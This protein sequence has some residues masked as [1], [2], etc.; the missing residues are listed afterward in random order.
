VPGFR[1]QARRLVG[2]ALDGD[3]VLAAGNRRNERVVAERA[4]RQR[5]AL[6]VV[7]AHVLFREHQHMM[8]EPGRANGV[9]FAGRK[10]RGQV[11]AADARAT[12]LSTRLDRN[13]HRSPSLAAVRFPVI[14]S[15]QSRAWASSP[16]SEK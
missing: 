6:E 15:T 13:A 5:E 9:D 10:R 16:A 3:D 14:A 1:K 12:R 2:L 11:H 4:H 7:I 8:L